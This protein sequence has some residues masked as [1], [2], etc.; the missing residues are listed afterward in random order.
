MRKIPVVLSCSGK[1]MVAKE[2]SSNPVRVVI[3]DDNKEMRDMVIRILEN[4]YE[5]V[6]AYADGQ[7]LV[8]AAK[9]LKPEIGIIDISMPIMNGIHAVV[10]LNRLGSEMKV[11]FLTVNEDN[12]FVRAAFDAGASAYV[13][14]RNMASDLLVALKETLAGRQFISQGCELLP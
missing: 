13:T 5:I 3:A 7:A 8:D 1:D 14:K 12:D 6:G 2:K 9:Q 10:E 11:V 4:E